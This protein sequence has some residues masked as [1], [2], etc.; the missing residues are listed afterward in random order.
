MKQFEFELTAFRD[1]PSVLEE[2][3]NQLA[4]KALLNE[5]RKGF[6]A[7]EYQCDDVGAEDWGWYFYAKRNG[8]TY[9]CGA[10]TEQ[11]PEDHE[12]EKPLW[13][14]AFVEH[15]RGLMDRLRGRNRPDPADNSA[16][17]LKQVLSGLPGLLNLRKGD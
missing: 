9:L 1:A 8:S 17:T 10:Q 4:G 15:E 2:N 16:E 13:G 6:V 5:I 12:T 3:V 11:G 14:S 7:A